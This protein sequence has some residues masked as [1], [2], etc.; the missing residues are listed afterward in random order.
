[1]AFSLVAL[2]PARAFAQAC[3]AAPSLV[4]P[5]RL[6]R[7]ESYGVGLQLRGRGVYGTFGADGAYAR[8]SEGDV[9]TAQELFAAARPFERAQFALLVRFVET[10]RRAAGLSDTGGGIGDVRAAAHVELTLAG[11]RR[12]VPGIALLVGA[13]FP[14]GTAPDQADGVLSADATGT[15]AWEGSVGLEI[16]QRFESA[17][18]SLAGVVGQRAPRDASGVSQSFA[19]RYTVIASGGVVLPN[20]VALGAFV[21]ALH[22]GPSRDRTADAEIQGTALSLLTTGLGATVPVGDAWRV[23][24]TL[25]VDL[26][27]VPVW[28]L[29][30]LGRNQPTGAGIAVS[31]L[32]LWR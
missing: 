32:R 25:S 13:A 5:S 10:R 12:W 27:H 24:G 2:G 9:E 23:Q 19:P 6:Q 30:E 20:E 18:V 3:C 26:P 29:S 8:T 31:M 16:D 11:E 15:G 4:I 22:Q 14:T 28:P 1:V 17:F 21:T 7:H